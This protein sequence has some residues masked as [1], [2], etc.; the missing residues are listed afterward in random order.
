M[1]HGHLSTSALGEGEG[2][3]EFCSALLGGLEGEEE[4]E[5]PPQKYPRRPPSERCA[6]D[7]PSQR[8]PGER[9]VFLAAQEPQVPILRQTCSRQQQQRALDLGTCTMGRA[10]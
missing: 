7:P 1:T 10:R 3:G 2:E 5:A 8:W 9:S 6:E 4:E